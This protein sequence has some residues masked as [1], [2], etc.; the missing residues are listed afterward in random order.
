M[1]RRRFLHLSIATVAS[2]SIT[3]LILPPGWARAATAPAAPGKA[4]APGTAGA[5]SPA[6]L[7]A[8]A[9]GPVAA[10]ITKAAVDA[11]GGMGRFVHRGDRVV[12]K[13]NI[14]WDRTPEQAANTNPDV[15]GSVVRLCLAAGAKSVLVLDNPCNDPRRCYQRSGIAEAVRAAGGTVDFFEEDRTRKM[16]IGGELIKEWNVH[17]AFTEANVRIN[18]PIAKHH[19]LAGLTLGM[20]NWLG[21]VGGDRGRMHQEMDRCIV[22]LAAFFKPSLTIIDGVRILTSGGPQGGDLKAVRRLDTV[23][24][25]A[26]QVAAEARGGM[27][28]GRAPDQ[29]PHI[30]LAESRGLGRG[31]WEGAE[32]LALE[33]PGA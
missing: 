26:D 6:P 8:V 18:V 24:A 13:A 30:A 32:E 19:S 31:H 22:D 15:V 5:L 17:P 21:A 20:K 23:I 7:L 10:A 9:H 28:H 1:K 29:L 3:P 12:V 27:L 16:I 11:L 14:G 4:P 33:V 2:A 25:S